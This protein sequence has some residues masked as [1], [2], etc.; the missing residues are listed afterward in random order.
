MRED[1]HSFLTRSSELP[2]VISSP[3]IVINTQHPT[4]ANFITLQTYR[5]KSRSPRTCLKPDTD[6]TKRATYLISLVDL[7]SQPRKRHSVMRRN[8]DGLVI[9]GYSEI[10]R[11]HRKAVLRETN[12]KGGEALPHGFLNKGGQH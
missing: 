1:A 9:T 7:L 2:A 10:N 11:N 5:K 4:L 12:D 3:V 6:T 8:F